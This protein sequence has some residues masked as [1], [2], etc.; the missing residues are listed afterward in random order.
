M[1]IVRFYYDHCLPNKTIKG[2]IS[3]FTTNPPSCPRN[4]GN[5]AMRAESAAVLRPA[6]SPAFVG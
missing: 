3:S 2:I 5:A 4:G 1:S 6:A